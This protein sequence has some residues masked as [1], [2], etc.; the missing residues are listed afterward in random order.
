MD[1]RI[2][3]EGGRPLRHFRQDCERQGRARAVLTSGTVRDPTKG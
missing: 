2:W 3:A 1:I